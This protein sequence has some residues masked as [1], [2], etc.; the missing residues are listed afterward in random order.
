MPFDFDVGSKGKV[1]I[2]SHRGSCLHYPENTMPAF[3]AAL[4]AGTSCIEIDVA[5]TKDNHIVVTH[6]PSVAR[7]S[8]GQGYVEQMTLE[9]LLA[10][11]F[12][13]W[14]SPAFS[15][16]K[17]PVFVDV[18]NWAIENNAGLVVEAKQRLR[19]QEFAVQMVEILRSVPNAV[20]HIQLLGFDHVL[21]NRV[22]DLMPEVN[23]QVVTLA[24]YNDQLKAVTDSRA[25]CVCCEYPHV[26]VDDLRAYKQAGL[27][28]RLYLPTKDIDTTLWFNEH[29]G[30]DV[31]SEIIGWMQEGLIDMI[32]HDDIE[33][34][35]RLVEEA[36]LEAI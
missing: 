8:D 10:L 29:Y 23:L 24:R 2:N 30:Y 26:S 15:G 6:D 33:M 5:M 13:G 35:K 32:S 18:L 3:N 14:F 11:D 36:G 16:T 27:T 21:V 1:L 12:G 22:K 17:V 7:T 25:S 34:L 4:D 31:H 9:E 20:D 28:T 19:H